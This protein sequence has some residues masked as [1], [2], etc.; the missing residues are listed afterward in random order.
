MFK[1]RWTSELVFHEHVSLKFN[2]SFCL[3]RIFCGIWYRTQ[4]DGHE[5]HTS[6]QREEDVEDDVGIIE[7]IRSVRVLGGTFLYCTGMH[8]WL[9]L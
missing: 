1:M 5:G 6:S 8:F 3:Y 7:G 9:F 4:A 2:H